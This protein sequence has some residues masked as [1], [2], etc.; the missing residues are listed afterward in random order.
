[1]LLLAISLAFCRTSLIVRQYYNYEALQ[2]STVHH[3]PMDTLVMQ[4][5]IG[6]SSMSSLSSGGQI[7]PNF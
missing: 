2:L 6:R 3:P 4:Y 5:H 7:Y 1:M